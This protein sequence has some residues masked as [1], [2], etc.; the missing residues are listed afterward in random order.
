MKQSSMLRPRPSQ[1]ISWRKRWTP[2]LL[3]LAAISLFGCAHANVVRIVPPPVPVPS[4]KA[5]EAQEALET[6]SPL[7]VY[8]G[9]IEVYADKIDRLR[10]PEIYQ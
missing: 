3:L 4:E 1:P 7:D 5:I 10:F 6:G 9:R 2:C 8:L